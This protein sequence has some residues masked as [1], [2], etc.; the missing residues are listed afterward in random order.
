MTNISGYVLFVFTI[1]FKVI[2][3]PRVKKGDTEDHQ[4]YVIIEIK[5]TTKLY[6]NYLQRVL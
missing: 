6:K 2:V 3:R 4:D 5:S 1:G